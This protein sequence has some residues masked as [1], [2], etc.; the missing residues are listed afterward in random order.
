MVSEV[1]VHGKLAPLFLGLVVRQNI[2]AGCGEVKL[3]AS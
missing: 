3:L 2:I 1:L